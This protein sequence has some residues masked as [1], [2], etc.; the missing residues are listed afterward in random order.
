MPTLD[1]RK[2]KYMYSNTLCYVKERKN[3]IVKYDM[4]ISLNN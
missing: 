1:L 2:S 4:M 3:I